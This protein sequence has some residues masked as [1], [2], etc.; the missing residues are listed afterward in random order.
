MQQCLELIE[1]KLRKLEYVKIEYNFDN[2][3]SKKIIKKIKPTRIIFSTSTIVI[4]DIDN[5]NDINT[6]DFFL[7]KLKTINESYKNLYYKKRRESTFGYI[8]DM[9]NIN[10][11]IEENTIT[12]NEISNIINFYE[13]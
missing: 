9:D 6:I 5:D 2:N 13:E 12:I 10:E 1:E 3:T 8:D 4:V 11:A 7:N